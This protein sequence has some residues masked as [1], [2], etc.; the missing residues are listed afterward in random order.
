MTRLPRVTGKEVMAALTRKGSAFFM[1][2]AATTIFSRLKAV[3]W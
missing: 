1:F 2:A 3:F